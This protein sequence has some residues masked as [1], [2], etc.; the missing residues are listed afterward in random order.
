MD[1]LELKSKQILHFAVRAGEIMLQSG[2]ETYRVEDTISRILKSRHFETV[3]TFVIPTCII[4]TIDSPEIELITNV[5]RIKNRSTRLDK[6]TLVNSLSR[7]YVN[8]LISTEDALA[9]IAI[10]DTI[11]SYSPSLII[12]ATG[13]SAAFFTLMVG[14]TFI[15]FFPALIFGFLCALIKMWLSNRDV[16]PYLIYFISGFTIGSGVVCTSWIIPHL[17]IDSVVIGSIMPLVP[18]VAFTNA[19]RDMIGDEL[20]SGLSRGIEA[21]FIAVSIAA[22]V[23]IAMNI[24]YSIGGFSL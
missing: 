20:I 21:L 17:Q 1:Q 13:I 7:K 23:G 2:A 18:G 10:I 3:E 5:K 6:I 22:G 9:E 19:I 12:C 15:D 16:T 4:A 14:G 8:N 24:F 11:E